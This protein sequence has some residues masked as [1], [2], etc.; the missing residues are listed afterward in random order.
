MY[1]YAHFTF[2]IKE[3]RHGM[4]PQ[5][6]IFKY[7]TK[8]KILNFTA[9]NSMGT[10]LSHIVLL[11]KGKNLLVTTESAIAKQ[12]MLHISKCTWKQI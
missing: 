9:S 12:E 2:P 11:K 10:L 4:V 6:Q 7:Q 8:I 1:F 5:I 3:Q